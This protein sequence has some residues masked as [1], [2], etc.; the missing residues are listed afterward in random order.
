[1]SVPTN[2]YG[3]PQKGTQNFGNS[4]SHP[5]SSDERNFAMLAHVLALFVGFLGPL[6][7]WLVKKDESL[8]V[9]DQGREALNFQLT[10]MIATLVGAVL[11]L[12][13]IGLFLLIAVIII[14]LVFCI[15]GAVACSKGELYRYPLCIRFIN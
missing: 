7:I 11:T 6:I 10:V 3:D 12:V 1:M 4:M 13:I 5:P 15:L 9:A 14:N 2:P 8:Y